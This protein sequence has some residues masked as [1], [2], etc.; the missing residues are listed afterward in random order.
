MPPYNYSFCLFIYLKVSQYKFVP[1]DGFFSLFKKKQEEQLP[2]Y[3]W[4]SCLLHC[5]VVHVINGFN[6][7]I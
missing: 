5:G 4:S 6:Y 3:D 2:Q 7:I 1:Q